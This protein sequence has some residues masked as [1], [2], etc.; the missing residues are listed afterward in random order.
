MKTQLISSLRVAINVLETGTVA[1]NWKVQSSC[2]CGVVSKAVLQLTKEE[3][4]KEMERPTAALRKRFQGDGIGVTWKRIIQN[5]CSITG[6]TE[7]KILNDL[8]TNGFSP[9]DICHLEFLEN[10]AILQR[11]N[12]YKTKTTTIK[13]KTGETIT[14][15]PVVM[16][17]KVKAK[18]IKGLFGGTDEIEVV[19]NKTTVIE[20]F[21]DEV[22]EQKYLEKEYYENKWNLI[23]YLKAWVSIL[24]EQEK[25]VSKELNKTELHEELLKAVSHENYEHAS[26]IRDLIAVA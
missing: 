6:K 2:N 24:E 13:V 20:T 19:E 16:K 9:A 26:K 17:T 10:P 11:A 21:K 5:H 23:N 4:S 22:R 8:F 3:I 12:L 14:T 25:P 1:Y 7:V 15:T 18:G